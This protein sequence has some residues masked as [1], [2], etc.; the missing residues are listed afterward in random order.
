[1]FPIFVEECVAQFI[2][3]TGVENLT[4]YDALDKNKAYCRQNEEET[5]IEIRIYGLGKEKA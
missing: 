2:N 3:E 5:H 1:M 4:F